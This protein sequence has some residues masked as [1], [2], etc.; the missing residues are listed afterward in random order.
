MW[1]TSAVYSAGMRPLSSTGT[2]YNAR[3]WGY[4]A[5]VALGRMVRSLRNEPVYVI[6]SL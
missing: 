5:V 6:T 4:R 3:G 1:N 2:V